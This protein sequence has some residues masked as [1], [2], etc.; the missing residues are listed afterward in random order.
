MSK[1]VSVLAACVFGTALVFALTGCGANLDRDV[2]VQE[3]T[4]SVPSTWAEDPDEGN[5]DSSGVV[6][7]ADVDED[8]DEGDFDAISVS[9]VSQDADD[10]PSADEKL[11]KRQAEL[12]DDQSVVNWDVEDFE[13]RVI[14]GAQVSVYDYSFE[15]AIDHETQKYEYHLAYIS[16]PTTQYEIQ[17]YGDAVS[18]GDIVENIEF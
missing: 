9:Y 8:K 4:M 7:F 3:M 11:A 1:K 17:V 14:D 13:T 10:A 12:E 15:K 2:T 16:T 6:W 5:R 18:L